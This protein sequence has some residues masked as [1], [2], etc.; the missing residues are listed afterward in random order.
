M[1]KSFSII[2]GIVVIIMAIVLVALNRPSDTALNDEGVA[3]ASPGSATYIIDDTPVSL[4]NGRAEQLTGDPQIR[5]ITTLFEATTKGDVNADGT[6]DTVVILTRTLGGSGTFYY[7]AA[8]LKND[9]GYQG[10]NAILL[11]DRIAP[12]T[13]EV[14]DGFIIVNYAD[15][16]E[17]EP[18]TTPPSLGVSK[19]L[20]M[21]GMTLVEVA[22]SNPLIQVQNVVPGQTVTSPLTVT[23]IAKGNW[24]F[25]AS[26]PVEVR[27]MNNVLLTQAPAQAQADW[28]TTNFVPFSVTLTFTSV[29]G[30]P[31]TIILRK[32]NPSGEPQNDDS[33]SIPVIF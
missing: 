17:G 11:G 19:Y 6:E 3:Q 16:N 5:T 12:Q 22:V 31:G 23:G 20:R 9:T 13:A 33:I 29:P 25:E 8:A 24:Y 32:D 7:A 21:Q 4:V 14:R 30:Q 10:T 28:M 15:R 2:L 18:M 26:F 1:K 27:D